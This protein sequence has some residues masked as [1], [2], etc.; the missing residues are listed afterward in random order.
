MF[1]RKLLLKSGLLRGRTTISYQ[2]NLD[3]MFDDGG[4]ISST[5]TGLR[6]LAIPRGRL[7]A[8]SQF[9]FAFGLAILIA[10]PSQV[11]AKTIGDDHY[12]IFPLGHVNFPANAVGTVVI[13]C[14]SREQ[15]ISA[16]FDSNPDSGK[17]L[18]IINFAPTSDTKWVMTLRNLNSFEVTVAPRAICRS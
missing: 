18:S 4:K 16:G 12:R 2:N 9:L 3:R 14:K 13:K 6:Q 5:A 15:I 1:L 8:W 11:S 10:A 17:G 7:A